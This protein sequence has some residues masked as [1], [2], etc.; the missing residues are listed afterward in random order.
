MIEPGVSIIVPVYNALPYLEEAIDSLRSQSLQ[1]IEIILVDDGSS[2]GSAAVCDRLAE[3]DARIRVIHK[4]NSGAGLSRNEGLK[5]ARGRYVSFLDADDRLYP[6]A[7]QTMLRQADENNLDMVRATRCF[8]KDKEAPA[9]QRYGTPLRLFSD[10]S[11]LDRMALAYIGQ[12][13]GEEDRR[14]H[15]EGGVW[16]ALYKREL[17]E[18]AG[19]RFVSEREYGSED[20]IFNFEFTRV[21]SKVGCTDDTFVHYRLSPGSISR[22]VKPDCMERLALHS[23]RM[24]QRLLAAGYSGYDSRIAA[25][26]YFLEIGRGLMKFK[27]LGDESVKQRLDWCKLQCELPYVKEI[28]KEYPQNTL[29]RSHRLHL[30]LMKHGAMRLLLILTKITEHIR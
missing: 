14:L 24:E 3:E 22:T 19:I 13:R 30:W 27:L 17:L 18:R 28:V 29:S 5:I 25:M 26:C 2:D 6:E 10:R 20:F 15:F 4:P 23:S 16:G 21:A 7:L 12:P 1:E 8:F 9:N 11:T